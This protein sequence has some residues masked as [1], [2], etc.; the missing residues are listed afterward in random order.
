[1]DHT[2]CGKRNSSNSDWSPGPGWS[3]QPRQEKG[4]IVTAAPPARNSAICKQTSQALAPSLVM[5]TSPQ[6]LFSPSP[7]SHAQSP[8]LQAV[9]PSSR[10]STSCPGSARRGFPLPFYNPPLQSIPFLSPAPLLH[11]LHWG[12]AFSPS[13]LHTSGEL[14]QTPAWRRLSIWVAGAIPTKPWDCICCGSCSQSRLPVFLPARCP[15]SP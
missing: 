3:E 1:M 9:M 5:F 4:C 13:C 11:L 10:W 14:T 15:T 6:C 2:L 7:V 12:E 8:P